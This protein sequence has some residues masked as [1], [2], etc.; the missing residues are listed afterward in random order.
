MTVCH[1]HTQKAVENSQGKYHSGFMKSVLTLYKV[2]SNNQ[3]AR[4]AQGK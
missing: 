2:L 4:R 1:T 3:T